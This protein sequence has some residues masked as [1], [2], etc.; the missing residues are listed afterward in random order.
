MAAER[1]QDVRSAHRP[2]TADELREKTRSGTENA[3]KAQREKLLSAKRVRVQ[4]P[5]SG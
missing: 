5:D 1:R 4:E 2:K 3:R